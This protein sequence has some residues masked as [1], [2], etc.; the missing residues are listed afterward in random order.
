MEII[1]PN[2]DVFKA[3]Y[4]ENKQDNFEWFCYLLFC[5]EYNKPNGILRYKNQS[6]I[7]T[8][9]VESNHEIIGW[10]SKFYEGKLSTHKDDLIGT[11]EKSKRDYLNITKILFY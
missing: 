7:E 8:N 10:Q 9:P 3:K 11:L 6:G 5:R 4:S 1:K 2:W